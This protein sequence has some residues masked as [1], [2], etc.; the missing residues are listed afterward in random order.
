MRVPGRGRHRRRLGRPFKRLWAG[1]TL[2]SSGDGFVFSAV[3]LL[4]VVVN[5]HPLAVSSVAAA[6]SLPWLL[7]ALPAGAFADRFE[8]GPVM[9]LANIVRAIVLVCGA[10]LIASHRMSLFLLILVVLVNA[11]GRAIYYSSLQAM[12]PELVNVDA[13]ERANGVLNG[14]ESATEHLVGPV[15]GSYLFAL[16]R[17]LPFVTDAVALIGSCIPFLRFRSKAV[18]ST[19]A[20]NSVWEGVRLLFADRRLRILLVVVSLLALFQGMEGG[21]L[22]LLAT[23]QW[24]VREGAYGLFLA[25]VA[26]GNLVGSALAEGQVRRFGSARVLV[27]AAVLSGAG[28]LAMAA[29]SSWTLAAPA[30]ALVGVAVM[31]INVVAIS[32]RQRLTP[33]DLMGRVGGAWRG[34]V[35]GAAPVGA[36]I[37]GSLAA[38]GGLRLPILL[39]GML[40]ILVAAVLARPLFRSLR[41]GAPAHD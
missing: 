11:G 36:L 8:R 19:E 4:A 16:S 14:T 32:L 5:P 2:A 20:S 24:G 40:Q 26:L 39:A 27:G 7:L 25:T 13:L 30:F 6:D 33:P 41:E 34:V 23:T 12:V 9:A 38:V 35:W 15:V 3:P 18:P 28:Y 1:F 22:V 29:A 17:P 10:V 37:A 31:L 21:V